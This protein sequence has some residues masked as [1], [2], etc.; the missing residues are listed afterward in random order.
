[1]NDETSIIK[2]TTNKNPKVV[3][4]ADLNIFVKYF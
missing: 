2:D 3:V 1:M 4:V